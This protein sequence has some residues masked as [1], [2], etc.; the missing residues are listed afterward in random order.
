MCSPS[1]TSPKRLYLAA[2]VLKTGVKLPLRL[3]SS[4]SR[5]RISKTI[6]FPAR[7]FKFFPFLKVGTQSAESPENGLQFREQR[8][9]HPL[10]L[11]RSLHQ[12][13]K[14]RRTFTLSEI[15]F[16]KLFDKKQY[17]F[18]RLNTVCKR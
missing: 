7:S 5:K 4:P 1:G 17:L 10:G 9:R 2:W 3:Y 12:T 6:V 8:T 18:K 13:I 16:P 11:T 14:T 15:N